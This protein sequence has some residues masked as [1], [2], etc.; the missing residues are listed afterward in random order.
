M[1]SLISWALAKSES[2]HS[3]IEGPEEAVEAKERE[4]LAPET[5]SNGNSEPVQ[6]N[7]KDGSDS[8][9]QRTFSYDQLKNKS[10]NPVSEIDVKR[11]EVSL[12]LDIVLFYGLD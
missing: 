11:R 4:E 7:G 2:G 1:T 8:Q 12:T 10:D 3:E 5:G 6:E 9:S